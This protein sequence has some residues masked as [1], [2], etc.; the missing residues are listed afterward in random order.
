MKSITHGGIVFL[1]AMLCSP[2]AGWTESPESSTFQSADVD[3]GNTSSWTVA[4]DGSG[5]F[6]SIQEAID[7]AQSG[8]TIWIKAGQYQED[9]TVHSK[10]HLTITGAGMDQV[11]ILGLNRVGTLHVGK[12]PYGAADIVIQGMSIEQHGGLGVGI[13]NGEHI[14]FRFVRVKG[15]V[16]GQQVGGVTIEDSVIGGSETTGVAFADSEAR[17]VRNVIHDNDHGVTIGGTSRVTLQHNVI[18]RSLFEA[19]LVSDRGQAQLFQNTLEGNGGGVTFQ[20]ESIG[21]VRGNIIG[22]SQ[23]AFSLSPK[24]QTQLSHNALHDNVENYVVTGAT[25]AAAVTRQGTHDLHVDPMFVDAEHGDYRLRPASPL[26]RI[27]E[28][29]YLGAKAPSER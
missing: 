10:E 1:A 7:Q 19:V 24:S 2:G 14:T 20:N 13:F 26:L 17:L 4:L 28:F 15:M 9:V 16:F 21:E 12:W 22:Q 3:G 23:V 11:T 8:D 18:T 29:P 6:K 27:G 25:P 5:Q